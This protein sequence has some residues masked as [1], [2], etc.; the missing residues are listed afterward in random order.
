MNMCIFTG[1]RLTYIEVAITRE[2]IIQRDRAFTA[3]ADHTGRARLD[4]F[5]VIFRVISG[6]FSP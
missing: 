1:Q 5:S 3:F 2:D 6:M 4:L